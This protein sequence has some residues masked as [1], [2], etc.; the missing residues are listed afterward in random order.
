MRQPHKTRHRLSL[1]SLY[2]IA[3]AFIFSVWLML[4]NVDMEAKA[5]R[6]SVADT[7]S[8]SKSEFTGRQIRH[9]FHWPHRLIQLISFC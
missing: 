2:G 4:K 5:M 6:E 3:L 1:F 7:P 8:T 9:Q